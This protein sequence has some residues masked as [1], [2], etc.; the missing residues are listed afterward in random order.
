MDRVGI[1]GGT[2]DPI[3]LGHL[4]PAEYAVNHLYLSRLILVPS[5]MPVHRPRH[6]PASNEHRLRM[7]QLAAEGIPGFLVSGVEVSRPEPSYTILTLRYFAK[8]LPAG[9]E[10]V[11]LVGEDNLP[12]LHTWKDI[13]EIL[14]LATLAIMP[15]PVAGP[16]DLSALKA[17]I[18]PDKVAEILAN[19]VPTPLVPISATAIRARVKAGQSIAGLVPT[20][21]ATYIAE[22]GLYL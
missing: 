18:G 16:A 17:A 21:V 11:L 2:F 19:R 22:N 10:I 20:N 3:H 5:A 14:R 12:M 1:L 15:R 8:T 4:V 6:T 9:T 7:C 13:D